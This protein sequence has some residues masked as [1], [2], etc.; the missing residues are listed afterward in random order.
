MWNYHVFETLASG[1]NTNSSREQYK[2]TFSSSN[3]NA[4]NVFFAL[5][6]FG[7]AVFSSFEGKLSFLSNCNRFAK[8]PKG[9]VRYWQ[10]QKLKEKIPTDS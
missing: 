9:K 6:N 10:L 3:F 8:R 1:T 5:F 7:S 4:I 2:E